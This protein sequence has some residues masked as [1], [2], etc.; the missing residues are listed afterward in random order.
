[1]SVTKKIYLTFPKN[2]ISEPVICAMYDKHRVS[3]NIR[4]ASVTDDI[5]IMA[6]ELVGDSAEKIQA[7]IG[8]FKSAGLTVD[9]IEMDVIAG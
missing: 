8:F 1:M 6:L 3:F 2:K 5:G 7:A 4:S 9:P